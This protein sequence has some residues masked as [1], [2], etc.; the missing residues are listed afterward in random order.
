MLF[1]QI[2]KG[3]YKFHEEYWENISTSGTDTEIFLPRVSK[4]PDCSPPGARPKGKVHCTTSARPSLDVSKLNIKIVISPIIRRTARGHKSRCFLKWENITPKGNSRCLPFS[5][6][7][8]QVTF[9]QLY[10]HLFPSNNQSFEIHLLTKLKGL[11][12][13]CQNPYQIESWRQI[14]CSAKAEQTNKITVVQLRKLLDELGTSHLTLSQTPQVWTLTTQGLMICVKN[15]TRKNA[16]MR[17]SFAIWCSLFFQSPLQNIFK[18][19]SVWSTKT[20]TETS[21]RRGR[22]CVLLLC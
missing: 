14:F 7:T 18:R 5:A 10:F 19:P 22:S 6:L 9:R 15:M 21:G 11:S 3:E 16:L 17:I 13:F 20:R 4:G 1:E 2:L 8:Y 12:L